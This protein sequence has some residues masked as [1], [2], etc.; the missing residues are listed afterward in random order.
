M[1]LLSFHTGFYKS[2]KQRMRQRVRNI[3][4]QDELDVRVV[5]NATLQKGSD[6]RVAENGIIS[7]VTLTI[8]VN[9]WANGTKDG[10][11]DSNKE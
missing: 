1:F 2:N 10:W 8:I 9:R 7:P 4:L 11:I 3:W 6:V 5:E